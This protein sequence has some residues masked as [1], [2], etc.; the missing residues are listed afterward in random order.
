MKLRFVLP[1]VLSLLT[2]A[3]P[4][5]QSLSDDLRHVSPALEKY[6]QERLMGEVWK[7]PELSPRDRSLVTVAALVARNQTAEM[8]QHVALALVFDKRPK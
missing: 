5:A 3:A 6:G 7:R 2:C 8:A 1:A 4:W